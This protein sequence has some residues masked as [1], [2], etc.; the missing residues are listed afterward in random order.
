MKHAL[1]CMAAASLASSAPAQPS[2]VPVPLIASEDYGPCSTAAVV[3]LDRS[4]ALLAVR[5]GPS[6]R[7]RALARLRNGAAVFA[8]VRRGSWFGIVFA[9]QSGGMDCG[10]LQPTRV[11]AFYSGP[12]RSGWVHGAYLSGYADWVS[13]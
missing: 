6:L 5:S 2:G 4:G 1:V 3:G 13:P 9:Q 10:V 7:H 12:C 11:N 8:C